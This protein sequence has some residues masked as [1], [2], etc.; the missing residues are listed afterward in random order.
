MLKKPA[1][2]AYKDPHRFFNIRILLIA[3][4]KKVGRLLKKVR[5]KKLA[6]RCNGKFNISVLKI[7]IDSKYLFLNSNLQFHQACP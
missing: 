1:L 5:E 6:L 2:L 7:Y 4:S 3:L